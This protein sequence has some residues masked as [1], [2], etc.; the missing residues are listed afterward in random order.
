MSRHEGMHYTVFRCQYIKDKNGY[1]S[2]C[3]YRAAWN[4]HWMVCPYCA[5]PIHIINKKANEEE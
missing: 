3:G 5:K 1:V 4:K 2:G